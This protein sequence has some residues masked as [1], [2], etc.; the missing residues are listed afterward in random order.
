MKK[1]LVLGF[2]AG[3][4]SRIGA[5]P[6]AGGSGTITGMAVFFTALVTAVFYFTIATFTSSSPLAI[7]GGLSA[8]VFNLVQTMKLVVLT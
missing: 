8:F 7:M 4:D 2:G 1:G 5:S 3:G 6:L